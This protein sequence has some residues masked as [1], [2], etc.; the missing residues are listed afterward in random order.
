[1]DSL[2]TNAL[3]EVPLGRGGRGWKRF[4]VREG[5]K[6]QDKKLDHTE[7]EKAGNRREQYSMKES[8]VRGRC[9]K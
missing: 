5:G 3:P 9:S 8:T 6:Q 7:M 4:E 2:L 1:M